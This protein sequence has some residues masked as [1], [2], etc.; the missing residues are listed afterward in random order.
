MKLWLLILLFAFAF[1]HPPR[2]VEI[3]KRV[4]A[5]KTS[6]IANEETPIRDLS[7]FTGTL[8]N[9][10]SLPLKKVQVRDDL[11]KSFNS[12]EKWPECPSIVEVRDQSDC[13]SCWAFGVAEVATD[14]LCIATQGQHQERLSADDIVSCCADCG[15]KC[16]GG[17]TGMA[18]E[19]LR[20]TGIVTGG[21]Y[22]TTK[23]CKSYPFPPC[24]HGVE[25]QYPPCSTTPPDDPVCIEECQP[26]YPVEYKKDRHTFS[27]VYQLG[28]DVDEIKTEIFTNGPVDATFM[29]FEDFMTYKSGVYHHVEGKNISLHT[30]KIIGWGEED[31]EKYWLVVNSWNE[32]WGEKGLFKIRLGTNE[33]AIES[34]VEAGLPFY[35]YCKQSKFTKIWKIAYCPH[36][37][38][39][40]PQQHTT[41]SKYTILQLH[42]IINWIHRQ[43]AGINVR[44]ELKG[45]Y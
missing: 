32:D 7:Y 1:C 12:F 10:K 28:A 21:E 22:G 36:P 5:R 27:N 37:G 18:W 3:A 13:A 20:L 26:G 41:Y 31:G 29:V 4:N 43:T 45:A 40:L 2:L 14:R 25:G 38:V 8:L 42:L 30:V 24:E 17:Y 35:V 6:W 23:W 39:L 44:N 15:Y 16:K 19:Y 9:S 33:C 11:P 34:Q